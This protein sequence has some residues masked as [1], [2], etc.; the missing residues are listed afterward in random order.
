MRLKVIPRLCG[1]AGSSLF[2]VLLFLRVFGRNFL[3]LVGW[4]RDFRPWGGASY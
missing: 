3:G 2:F 4:I 1:A